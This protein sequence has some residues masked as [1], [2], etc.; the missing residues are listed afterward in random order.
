MRL[1]ELSL[2]AAVGCLPVVAH[3]QETAPQPPNPSAQQTRPVDP[4]NDERAIQRM[5]ARLHAE[6]AGARPTEKRAW[7]GI[8]VSPA[9]D[10]L[11]HQLKLGDGTG[12][13]VDFVEPGSPAAVAGLQQFDVLLKL[14][15]QVLVNPEQF[16]VLVR[17]QKPDD[18]VKLSIIR[19]GTRKTV[20]AKLVEHEVPRLQPGDPFQ[21]WMQSPGGFA[22]MGVPPRPDQFRMIERPKKMFTLIDGQR[23]IDI[24]TEDG[25]KML[26]VR[27]QPD[28]KVVLNA[29]IDTPEQMQSLPND[30]RGMLKS[31]PEAELDT[32]SS[33]NGGQGTVAPQP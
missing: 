8:G 27:V 23:E 25:H 16:A 14:E 31:L 29:P 4:K 28:G 26:R 1:L 24:S 11:R 21:G 10:A 22:P 18:E 2:L 7:L 15:E 33:D 17:L 5:L 9:A 13:V 12:L 32:P 30:V 20:S 3:A 19:E 6:T